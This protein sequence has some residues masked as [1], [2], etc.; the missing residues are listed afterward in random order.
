MERDSR[1]ASAQAQVAQNRDVCAKTFS[2]G[3]KKSLPDAEMTIVE[4][5]SPGS[6]MGR[7]MPENRLDWAFSYLASG[8]E[9][10]CFLY[11]LSFVASVR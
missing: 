10:A 3:G 6:P 9:G 11:M 5:S 8:D 1:A 4:T 2:V 7:W